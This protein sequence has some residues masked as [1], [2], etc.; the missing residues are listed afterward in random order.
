MRI[1]VT[2]AAGQLG[3]ALRVA[4]SKSPN[5]FIFTDVCEN[6]NIQLLDITNEAAVAEF[7]KVQKVDICL[8]CVAYTAVDK[9]EDEV[10]QA[11]LLNSAA[12]EIL[13]KVSAEN[14]IT[15]IHVSTDYVFDGEAN[16]PYTETAEALPK[17][18]YG[19]TK[20]AGEKA[21]IN[22]G[23]KYLIFRT[24]WLYGQAGRNF[25]KTILSLLEEKPSIKVVSDQF[26]SPTN[27]ADLAETL[28][29]IIDEG[30]YIKTGL[31][32]YSNEGVC[33]W[34][35]FAKA[36]AEISG[37]KTPVIP[38][39]TED[40]PTKAR[41]PAYSVLDKTKFKS[42]F[43]LEPPFWYD[44]LRNFIVCRDPQVAEAPQGDNHG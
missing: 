28:V 25:V 9:A 4:S 19:K 11:E 31:Y 30:L 2:G 6:E 38:C 42:T 3:S 44:S 12:P 21:L 22:S 40:F 32:H 23:C 24:S 33:S 35:D 27:A 20:L 18:I 16:K 5:S 13:A 10:E 37:S 14:N 17:T 15:L 39:T 34:Y 7:V 26:G 43:G 36:I 41:R 29:H 1:L 8:N